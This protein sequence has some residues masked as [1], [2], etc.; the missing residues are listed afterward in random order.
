MHKYTYDGPVLLFENIVQ[1][2]W[3]GETHAVSEKQAKNNL[4]YQYKI[5]HNYLPYA[6]I[7]L[8]GK[9]KKDG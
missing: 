1:A 6:K 5:E 3:I 7:T 9:V 4:Q 2:R 8:G